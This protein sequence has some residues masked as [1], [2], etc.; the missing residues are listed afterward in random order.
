ML[1]KRLRRECSRWM[2]LFPLQ[3]KKRIRVCQ[4]SLAHL[5]SG[6]KKL[7][8]LFLIQT[9]KPEITG[10]NIGIGWWW[11]RNKFFFQIYCSCWSDRRNGHAYTLCC[12]NSKEGS[13]TKQELHRNFD[14]NNNQQQYRSCCQLWER[15][16]GRWLLVSISQH[17]SLISRV[18]QP[19][20]FGGCIIVVLCWSRD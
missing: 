14:N 9:Q 12:R 3:E 8:E 17:D 13:D 20:S 5:D 18:A 7:T 19:I 11:G 2:Y 15:C 6:F 10:I 16:V 4:I 1:S